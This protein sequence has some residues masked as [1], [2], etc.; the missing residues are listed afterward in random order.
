M[1]DRILI[2]L[3]EVK[4]RGKLI[5]Q[6]PA[7]LR[8]CIVAVFKQ[9]GG[10][11]AEPGKESRDI[12]SRAFAICTASMKKR[13]MMYKKGRKTTKKAKGFLRKHSQEKDAT[14]KDR[15]YERIVKKARSR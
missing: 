5:S 12:L 15:E 10:D 14:K 4:R 6:H 1:R 3:E 7:A 13:G 11:D 8:H 2:S 9:S